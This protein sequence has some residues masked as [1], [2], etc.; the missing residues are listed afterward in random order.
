NRKNGVTE[1]V[2]E[3]QNL[4]LTGES[5]QALVTLLN[6][7]GQ[8]AKP[9][10]DAIGAMQ[11]RKIKMKFSDAELAGLIKEVQQTGNAARGET[12]YRRNNLN[13][14]KCHAIGGSGGIV[15]PDLISL[16]ASSPMDYIIESLVNPN[17]KIKEGYHTTTILTDDGRLFSGKL[18]S[19]SDDQVTLRDAEN[20]ELVF[21]DEEI[22][23]QKISNQSLMPTDAVATLDRVDFLDLVC[24]LSELGKE[25]PYRISPEAWVRR[26][27]TSDSQIVYSRVDGS[28]PMAD[29]KGT[30]V[31]FDFEVT[32]A[33]AIGIGL[34]NGDG[35]RVTLD[36]EKDNLQA[37]KIIKDL[38]PGKHTLHFQ[39]NGKKKR[40]PLRVRL[41]DLPDSTGKARLLN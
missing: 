35:L 38:K 40:A 28:L 31:S 32:K 30:T 37:T 25:G 10:S 4:E 8:R 21:S 20:K 17:A 33:G 27:A 22:E 13:C 9:L 19:Q 29:V 18:I 24:F 41:L 16:G 12:V 5:K 11:N 7:S 1:L 34:E 39:L 26:W 2:K 36:G 23:E 15:G 3:F 14:I 6:K